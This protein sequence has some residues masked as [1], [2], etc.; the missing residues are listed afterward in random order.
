MGRRYS[1]VPH[2]VVVILLAVVL[3]TA[4]LGGILAKYI[5]TVPVSGEVTFTAE[6]AESM[7]LT[8]SKANR[9]ESGA[10]TLLTAET[11]SENTYEVMPGVDIPKDP[12]I[13]VTGKTPVAAYLYVEISDNC[14]D[15]VTYSL[16]EKWTYI[17]T[18]TSGAEVYAY[19]DKLNA[20]NCGAAFQ[21]I[22]DDT[23]YVSDSA[24]MT[25]FGI[26]IS[27]VM[28]Q[29]VDGKTAA[30]VYSGT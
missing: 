25:G 14:P 1:K 11:V 29:A 9:G 4:C 30:Q 22:K 8:E 27:A 7:T 28:L 10:Y 13:T 6:L 18:L 5:R 19:K 21:I 15:G 2:I 12:R 20:G 3:T 26:Q 17:T 23:V 24:V 16:T